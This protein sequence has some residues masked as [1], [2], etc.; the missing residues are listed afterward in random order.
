MSRKVITLVCVRHGQADHNVEGNEKLFKYTQDDNPVLDTHLTEVG[1]QEVVLVGKRLAAQ[2]FDLSISSDLE[3]ARDTA[4]AI[5]TQ[6]KTIDKVEEWKIVR[7]RCLGIFE[8]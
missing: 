1:K 3:R 6:N 2:R 8:G 4:Q 5:S 7:E